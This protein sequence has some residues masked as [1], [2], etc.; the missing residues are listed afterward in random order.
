MI[1]S[2]LAFVFFFFL[3][4]FLKIAI[5]IK[6]IIITGIHLTQKRMVLKDEPQ[7]LE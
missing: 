5:Q 2:V 7:F 1:P 3:W 4:V 6:H